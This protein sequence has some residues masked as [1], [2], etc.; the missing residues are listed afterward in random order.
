[1]PNENPK[2]PEQDKPNPNPLWANDEPEDKGETIVN[3]LTGKPWSEDS[4]E[5]EE[6]RLL[7]RFGF[8]QPITK[9]KYDAK[10]LPE[11]EQADVQKFLDLHPRLK[12][13]LEKLVQQHQ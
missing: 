8:A 2:Q 11:F 7:V 12:E 13:K 6:M 10:E 9:A 3:S 1:M 4:G 5:S